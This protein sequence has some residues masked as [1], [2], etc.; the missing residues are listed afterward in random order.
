MNAKKWQF[1]PVFV[2]AV[3]AVVLSMSCLAAGAHAAGAASC[4]TQVNRAVNALTSGERIDA[5]QA[6]KLKGCIL[7]QPAQTA[8]SLALGQADSATTQNAGAEVTVL[9][10]FVNITIGTEGGPLCL[11][12]N[13]DGTI[14]PGSN[15]LFGVGSSGYLGTPGAFT[16]FAFTLLVG[17]ARST[18]LA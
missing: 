11:N 5:A 16:L 15:P 1:K 14:S 9:A 17:G 3:A 4:S 8:D 13:S 7:T 18:S 10:S 12:F 2:A 6:A